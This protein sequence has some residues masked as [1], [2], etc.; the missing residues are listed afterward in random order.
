MDRSNPALGKLPATREQL[1]FPLIILNAK[2][3]R[4][5]THEALCEDACLSYY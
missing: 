3:I 5:G 1:P 4:Q 2:Q